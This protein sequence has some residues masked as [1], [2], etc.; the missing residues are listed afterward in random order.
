MLIHTKRKDVLI[1]FVK[2]LAVACFS[3]RGRLGRKEYF[4]FILAIATLSY[5]VSVYLEI[6]E[7]TENVFLALVN[8]SSTILS[9]KRL[10]DWGRSPWWVLVVFAPMPVFLLWGL[11]IVNSVMPPQRRPQAE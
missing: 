4:L 6:S 7:I 2:Y 8:I 5:I 1:N 9:I 11:Y 10:R 3:F